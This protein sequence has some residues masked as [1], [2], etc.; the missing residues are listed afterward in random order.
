MTPCCSGQVVWGAM[1]GWAAGEG[2][3]WM[4]CELLRHS[5]R[6]LQ[7]DISER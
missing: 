5:C 2:E 3:L 1:L 7:V 6:L 4:T